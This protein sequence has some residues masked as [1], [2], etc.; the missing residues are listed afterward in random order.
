MIK[1]SAWLDEIEVAK[2]IA[3]FLVVFGHLA[4]RGVSPEFY[5]EAY[6]T[7]KTI[8]YSFH[9]PFFFF[10]SGVISFYSV[11]GGTVSTIDRLKRSVPRILYPYFIFGIV[12]V[13]LKVFLDGGSI[14]ETI[15]SYSLLI[16]SPLNPIV[17]S[18]W[19]LYVLFIYIALTPVFS[20]M[21]KKIDHGIYIAL[22]ML[23]FLDI[24]KLGQYFALSLVIKYLLFFY[25]GKYYIDNRA[26]IKRKISNLSAPVF[27]TIL[28]T[29]FMVSYFYTSEFKE[30]QILMIF[31][32]FI[33]LI[34]VAIS[35]GKLQDFLKI[36]GRNTLAIYLLSPFIIG[37]A[38]KLLLFIDNFNGGLFFIAAIVITIASIWVPILIKELSKEKFTPLHT[39]IK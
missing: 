7:I 12:T 35:T 6:V 29:F 15:E 1:K 20:F 32:S 22:L 17:G 5:S 25:L 26:D 9:M 38:K 13:T 27:F 2:G 36:L 3:I 37:M 39:L 10:L 30:V 8:I 21:E 31:L 14:Y 18:V 24:G 33:L 34:K 16:I 23:F 19:Y 11:R 4:S 28:I